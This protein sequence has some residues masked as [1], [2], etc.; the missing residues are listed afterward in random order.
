MKAVV[1]TKKDELKLMDVP[2]PQIGPDDVLVQSKRS[3]ICR[4]DYEV[5]EGKY[6]LPFSYPIIPGHE[7]SGQVVEV[8]K[9]VEGFAVGDRVVGECVIGCGS[10]ILCK[11]G[12]FTN[13][14]RAEHYGLTFDGA[15]AEYCRAIPSM[16]HKLPDNVSYQEGAM[17]EPFTIG[18][19][20]LYTIGGVDGGDTVLI[21]GAGP[22][23]LSTLIT[24]KGMGAR[25]ITVEPI[26]YRKELAKK[27][28]A[29][30]VLDPYKN[31]LVEAVKDLTDGMGADVSFEASGSDD[32]LKVI[33]EVTRNNGRIAIIGLNFNE[34]IPVYLGN[35]QKKGLIVKGTVGSPYVWERALRFL[36]Q[37]KPDLSLMNTHTFTLDEAEK[38]YE[39]G[40]HREKCL[41]VQIATS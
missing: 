35:I 7:W 20:A 25:A 12:N 39:L 15:C 31:N 19:Y 24:A 14:P 26:D 8:G 2:V 3:G 17:V 21:F 22:I 6:I 34:S 4:S 37:I 13:C 10:C 9:N 32:A 23:G 38:A 28:G 33:F 27:F 16:L 5:L 30:E 36:S 18:Y 1:F 41:K 11:S 29:D 40:R